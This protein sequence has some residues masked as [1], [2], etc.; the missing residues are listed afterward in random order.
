MAD[1]L[2]SI[3]RGGTPQPGPVS[4]GAGVDELSQ[5]LGST[6]QPSGDTIV[7]LEMP[8]SEEDELTQ[9]LGGRSVV[10]NR[11]YLETFTR[12]LAR[13][14][15]QFQAL[16]PSLRS[17]KADLEGRNDDAVAAAKEAEAAMAPYGDS[18]WN[19]NNIHDLESLGYWLF[20]KLGEQGV[21]ALATMGTG[22]AGALAA[23]A[24][25]KNLVMRAA[26]TKPTA[27]KFM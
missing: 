15:G 2:E 4:S 3:L 21:T 12:G 27:E 23:R 5:A 22:G 13:N 7:P 14:Y 1:D 17:L 18:D 10:A 6:P 25:T 16:S 26:M 19:L 11:S 20:E 9:A 8:P 24:E